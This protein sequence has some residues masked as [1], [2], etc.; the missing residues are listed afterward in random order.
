MRTISIVL[1]ALLSA[2]L[3]ANLALAQVGNRVNW[4]VVAG[5]GGICT[6]EGYMLTG[7]MGQTS[8]AT[9]SGNGYSLTGGY[10]TGRG[11]GGTGSQPTPKLYLPAIQR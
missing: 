5:G 2:L 1:G 6:G 11:T 9:S 8:T 10:W 3:V 7:T 4:T